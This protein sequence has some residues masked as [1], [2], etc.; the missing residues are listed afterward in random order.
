[1]RQAA[2]ALLA[3][4]PPS[5]GLAAQGVP[6][7]REGYVEASPG[8]RLFYRLVGSGRDTVVVLHGGPGFSMDYLAADL[9]PLAAEQALLFYDQRGTGRSSLVTDSAALDGERF[10]DDLEAVRRHFRLER[11]T[12]LGHSWGAG[13]AALYAARHPDRVGRLLIVDGI[14]VRRQGLVQAF[15]ALEESRD[16]ATLRQMRRWREAR[17]ANPG[18]AAACRAYY[19]LW[20]QPF[21]VDGAA[22]RRSKGDFCAGTPEALGNKVRSVDRFTVPSLGEWDWRPALGAVTA[23][24]LVIHGTAD[25]LPVATAREWAAALPNGRMLL[26]QRVGHFPYLEAPETFFAAVTE[27]VQGRWPRGAEVR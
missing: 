9:E 26:I 27:F 23:P 2:R 19:V 13:V 3:V 12:L 4:M 21:F 8:V 11:L 17:Q 16:S 22:A 1:M 20:F 14:P 10:A 6:A 15:Q 5:W 7:A 25:P 24:A 18:D